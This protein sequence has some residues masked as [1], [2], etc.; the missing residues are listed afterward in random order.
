[1]KEFKGIGAS[2]GVAIA[3][4]FKLENNHIEITQSQ[5]ANP[6]AEIEKYLDAVK[7]SIAQIQ[8]IKQQASARLSEEETAVF[9][10]H[11][12][13]AEDPIIQEEIQAMIENDQL[14]SEYAVKVVSDKY[15]EMFEL[16]DDAY[17]KERAADIKDVST[18][19]VKNLLKIDIA[20]LTLIDKPTIIVAEDLTPSETAQLNRQFVKGFLTNIGGRTSHSAIMAR[21]LEIPAILGIGNITDLVVNGQTVAM[22]GDKGLGVI[23]PEADQIAQFKKEYDAYLEL[24][25]ELLK[26]KG[27]KSLTKDNHEVIIASN[28]GSVEDVNGVLE[29]DSDAI[30]LF[31]SEFLYMDAQ[32][33]PSEEEQFQS[34]KA[35]LEKM[36]PK[37]VVVRTLDIGG[38]K[39]LK[40]FKF[41]EEMNPFLG[42]RA[43]RMSLDKKDTF[44]TQLR[45]LIRASAYGSL[46]IMFPMITTVQEFLDAKAIYEETKQK[47]IEEGHKVSNNIEVGMMVEV[48]AAAVLTE[49]FCKHAD[50]VSIGTNDLMQYTM[51]AD[52]MNEKVSYL[53]QPLNPSILKLIHMT[54]EGAHKAG[55]WVG[56]CGEMGGDPQAIPLLVGMGLDEFSMSA[57]SVLAARKQI[58]AI[59]SQ[60]AKKLVEKALACSTET[61]VKKLVN[62]FNA[63]L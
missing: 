21:S 43:I 35:V 42:Y 46:Q 20:D 53:Y 10:A 4:V 5:I 34:Y 56:M 52:R 22:N 30:G 8:K 57:T 33:W 51:A 29:N 60:D 18:R 41:P 63:S 24:K 19:I 58:S 9:D 38:D 59:N 62:E 61:E 13:V 23:D 28:I 40:Y 44:I 1:M 16:M 7:T 49:Q 50:F 17:M 32:D 36:S 55:K 54:I 12:Q 47:L 3:E 6:A 15:I 39:T 37:A 27:K 26:F 45:A 31:R 25:N 48:P 14:N 2:S 11:I